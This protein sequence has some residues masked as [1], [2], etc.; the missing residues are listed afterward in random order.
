MI[1]GITTT[2]MIAVELI[3]R[4]RSADAIGPRGSRIPSGLQE[5]RTK[6]ASAKQ[7]SWR[8]RRSRHQGHAFT[9]IEPKQLPVS[10]SREPAVAVCTS[11]Q[12]VLGRDAWIRYPPLNIARCHNSLNLRRIRSLP[13][14]QLHLGTAR[15]FPP[16]QGDVRA[17]ESRK[18]VITLVF[19]EP[20]RKDTR[21]LNCLQVLR[22]FET[23]FCWDA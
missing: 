18:P 23:E 5:P 9:L 3:R 14:G 2:S 13:P 6:A 21:D 8:E 1:T 11:V 19:P 12:T 10:L 20:S 17:S 22:T 15:R 16:L 7:E 4:S